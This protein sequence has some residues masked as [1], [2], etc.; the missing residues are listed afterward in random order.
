MIRPTRIRFD[1]AITN[2]SDPKLR[3]KEVQK[4]FKNVNW[5]VNTGVL[6]TPAILCQ[7]IEEFPDGIKLLREM[8]EE[9]VIYPDLHGWDHGP[10]A[11]RSQAEVEEHLDKSM[12]WFKKN[13][14]VLPIRWVT[15]HGADSAA[16]QAAAGK[17]NL[18]IETTDYPVIDQKTLDPRLRETRD[19]SVMTE[20]VVM[21]HWWEHGL[22]LYRIARII[23][24]Q[25]V[26]AAIEVTRS[27][28]SV[29]DHAICWGTWTKEIL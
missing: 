22:R 15:P 18:V 7:D 3:G 13:L 19:L 5:C 28:L 20:R 21:V 8:T 12:V 9:E 27:E 29:K 4:F 26:A 11:P 25:G 2:S 6:L 17:F 23:E 14:G 10:Y 24:H 16:M 1:D